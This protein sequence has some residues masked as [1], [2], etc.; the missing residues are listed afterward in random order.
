MD[1]QWLLTIGHLSSQTL[2]QLC[3]EVTAHDSYHNTGSSDIYGFCM[4]LKCT[5]PVLDPGPMAS[6]QQW[7]S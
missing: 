2:Q 7:A 5:L 3:E 4:Q 1:P 6:Q